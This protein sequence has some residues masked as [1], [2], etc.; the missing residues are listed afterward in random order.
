MACMRD[1]SGSSSSRQALEHGHQRARTLRV[2]V[3]EAVE[4]VIELSGIAVCELGHARDTQAVQ[5]FEGGAA[6]GLQG[7]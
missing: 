1:R 2:G 3:V 7:L 6:H 4:P 5:V